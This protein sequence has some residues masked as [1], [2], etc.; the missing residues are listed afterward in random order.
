MMT[1]DEMNEEKVFHDF[2]SWSFFVKAEKREN[3]NVVLG[4]KNRSRFS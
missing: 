4:S 2:L 1:C 3:E